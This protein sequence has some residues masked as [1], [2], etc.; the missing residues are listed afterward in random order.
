MIQKCRDD[1][2]KL[3]LHLVFD[4]EV[5]VREL[6]Q[7]RFHVEGDEGEDVELQS[8]RLPREAAGPIAL[9]PEAFEDEHCKGA[10]L[11]ELF[12]P[13]E[14]G[15]NSAYAGHVIRFPLPSWSFGS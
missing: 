7:L 12:M 13:E 1:A 8:L 3:A 9:G 11:L 15:L 6:H 10:Q 2:E 5:R 4:H 14:L